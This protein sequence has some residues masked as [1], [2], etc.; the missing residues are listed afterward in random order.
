M[1]EEATI[2]R[3]DQLKEGKGEIKEVTGSLVAVEDTSIVARPVKV[4]GLKIYY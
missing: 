2:G 4:L 1:K 3:K